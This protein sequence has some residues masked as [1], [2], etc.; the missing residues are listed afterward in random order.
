[1]ALS[2]LNIIY[3]F[4]GIVDYTLVKVVI[5]VPVLTL[6]VDV[7]SSLNNKSQLSQTQP[8]NLWLIN[9][10][11]FKVHSLAYIYLFPY[12]WYPLKVYNDKIKIAVKT[13]IIL[14]QWFVSNKVLQGK[15]CSTGLYNSWACIRGVN[16]SLHQRWK[17]VNENTLLM[18]LALTQ[19]SLISQSWYNQRTK[20]I[21]WHL[22]E[23][24]ACQNEIFLQKV[25]PQHL[26]DWSFWCTSFWFQL[27]TL[28]YFKRV[29]VVPQNILMSW[30]TNLTM[31]LAM[32]RYLAVCRS[33]PNNEEYLMRVAYWSV[34]TQMYLKLTPPFRPLYY[35][36]LELTYTRKVK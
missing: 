26:Q 33:K 10:Q 25:A 24:K 30:T 17:R 21:S 12:I 4:T 2:I 9:P 19:L 36:S 3:I 27:G 13:C 16:N 22:T 29:D 1:M 5:I 28:E 20:L 31:G 14:D 35:R 7:E 23:L 18:E 34:W 8:S 6:V 11:V 32:E 15:I